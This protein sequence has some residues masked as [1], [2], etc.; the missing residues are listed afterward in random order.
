MRT[1]G[2][3]ALLLVTVSLWS[4]T[5]TKFNPFTGKLDYIGL[6]SPFKSC[7]DAGST[8]D[9]ACSITPSPGSYVA[10]A[11]FWFKANTAN[12]GAAT[13]NLN[14]LGAKTIKKFTAVSP[15]ADLANNDIRA[16]QWVH[17]VYDGTNFQI[18]SAVG[19]AAAGGS[20]TTITVNGSALAD[21]NADFD[22][23]TPA[24]VGTGKNVI[25]QKDALSPTNISAYMP[26]ATSTV[27]GLVPAPPNDATKFL[28]GTGVFSTPSSGAT[29][30]SMVADR[31]VRWGIEEFNPSS[32]SSTLIGAWGWRNPGTCATNDYTDGT[33]GHPGQFYLRSS[34]VTNQVCQ[35]DMSNASAQ[36]FGPLSATTGFDSY[37]TVKTPSSITA[38]FRVGAMV[39]TAADPPTAGMWARYDSGADSAS[40]GGGAGWVYE[41]RDASSSSTSSTNCVAITTSQWYTIRIR[42]VSSGKIGMSIATDTG[43]FSTETTFCTAASGCDVNSAKVPTVAISPAASN[44]CRSS[45]ATNFIL[46]RYAYTALGQ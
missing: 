25:W 10:G 11:W 45:T 32:T 33:A 9:Y 20:G 30:A 29:P 2:I 26:V 39:L 15:G 27:A 19:N 1:F 13:L 37:W 46:D 28:D 31:T 23:S 18:L 6:P 38:A 40:C 42:T 41:V 43:A 16:G 34:G 24:A 4:Q 8:D 35:L 17:V 44:T 5:A 3:I 7:L 21:T 12:T 36:F 14:S 22:D